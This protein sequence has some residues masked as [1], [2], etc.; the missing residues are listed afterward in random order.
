[1]PVYQSSDTIA[2]IATPPGEGGIAIVRLSGPD[3]LRIADALYRGKG[4]PPSERPAPCLCIGPVG[5]DR[6]LIDEAVM[7]VMKKPQS[8]TVEDV[9][10]IQ[11]HGGPIS[12]RR[13]LECAIEL[14]A[15]PAEPGEFTARAFLNGRLDLAQAEAVADLIHAQSERAARVAVE[16]LEG[17]LSRS[18]NQLYDRIIEIGGDLAAA[19]D[20]PEEDLPAVDRRDALARLHSM[21]DETERLIA[22]RD[23]G[24]LLRKGALAVILGKPNTGKSTLLN[25]LLETERAIVSHI[26]GTTRDIIEETVLIDGFPVRLV[27]TAG[28]RESACEIEREGIRRTHEQRERADLLL[29]VIDGSEPVDEK[30]RRDIH[31]LNPENSILLLNKS[32]LGVQTAPEDWPEHTGVGL[33]LKTGEG[34]KALHETLRDRLHALAHVSVEP[35][36]AISERHY[37]ALCDTRNALKEALD[38]IKTDADGWEYAAGEA[39]RTAAES[40]A[41]IMG[42]IVEEDVL[43]RVFSTFC[44]GK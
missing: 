27:D 1:M 42:R 39:L 43:D 23:E 37:E 24:R 16:Q 12:A 9:I 13:I 44:I 26:P 33:S 36:T 41:R 15:R 21:A 29:Y 18:L 7:L 2:A 6:E 3:S 25:T 11:V 30:E 19:L 34:L 40:I 14:G 8:Y 38:N 32:D 17:S 28:L 5:N 20:F 4:K 31:S 10:E 35:H 22:T